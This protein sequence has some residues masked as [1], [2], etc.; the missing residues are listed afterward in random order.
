MTGSGKLVEKFEL[1]KPNTILQYVETT[2]KTMI[3]Y[4]LHTADHLGLVGQTLGK[5]W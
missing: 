1:S 4:T 2:Y 5:D 3:L